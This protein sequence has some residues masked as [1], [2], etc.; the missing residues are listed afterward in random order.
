MGRSEGRVRERKCAADGLV[1]W[2]RWTL[3]IGLVLATRSCHIELVFATSKT[4][5]LDI[6]DVVVK[7]ATDED[8]VLSRRSLPASEKNA[9]S[10]LSCQTRGEFHLSKHIHWWV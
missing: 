3:D 9:L 8:I 7:C 6:G 1:G 5:F 10:S 4:V 2:T